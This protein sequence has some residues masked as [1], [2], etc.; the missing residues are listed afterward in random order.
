MGMTTPHRA[1]RIN[2]L[3]D[4]L[5][6]AVEPPAVTRD[7]VWEHT[8]T[9]KKHAHGRLSWVLP[10]ETGVVVRSDVPDEALEAGLAAAL[11]LA[12][13]VLGEGR[14]APEALSE[15]PVR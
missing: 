9:D 11:G 1:E 5:D 14:V 12:P 6:L 8:A 15:T 10:T 13:T 7:A 3:L 2:A 4:R